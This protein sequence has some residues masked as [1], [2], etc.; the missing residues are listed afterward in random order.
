MSIRE[1]KAE[2][3]LAAYDP[4]WSIMFAELD[5]EIRGALGQKVLLLEHVGSTSVPGLAAKP[6][7]DVLLAVANSADESSFLPPLEA[8]GFALQFRE[9]EWFEHRLLR[10]PRIQ[11]NI[12]VFSLGCEEI[13]RMVLFRDWLRAHDEERLLYEQTKRDLALRSWN[14]VQDYADAKSE[15]VTAILSRAVQARGHR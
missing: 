6:V 4:A 13:D 12:H 2:I 8:A 10:A 14:R 9:P 5:H 15:I 1:D 7:V 3:F 11:S